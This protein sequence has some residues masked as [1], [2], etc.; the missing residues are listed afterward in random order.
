[1]RTV[2]SLVIGAGPSGLAVAYGLKGDT[3]VLEKESSVGGLCRSI[4]HGDGVF[5]IGGHSFHTPDPDVFELVQ[6]LFAGGLFH[7]RRDA[8][9]YSHDTLIP[10]PFQKYYDQLPDVDVIRSCEDG[11]RNV[12]DDP[13]KAANFE[14]YILRKFGA[15]IAEYFMLPYNRKLWARDIKKISCEWVSERVAAPKGEQ[16]KFDTSGGKRKPLQSDTNVGYPRQGGFEEIYR[17][18]VPHLTAVELN[19]TI[20]SIDPHARTAT[21]S[22]GRQYKWEILVSTLPLP[23]LVRAVAGTPAEI[24]EL[25]D[26]LEYMSLRVEFLLA[27]CR[28]ET[29]IQRIYAASPDIPAHKIALNHNS[30]DY[31]RQQPCHAIMAE[32]SLSTQK[33]VNVEEIAPRTIDFL[34]R[35]GVL[36]SPADI[37]W[38]GHVDVN[39]AYPVYTHQRPSLVNA[40]KEWMAGHDIYTVGRFGDWEYIN[41]DKCITKGLTLAAELHQIYKE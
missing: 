8:R 39:F 29:P 19:T 16:E 30:S 20:V 26:Q 33:Q 24:I 4:V 9:I 27:G 36:A 31:L 32:V 17:A 23:I 13:L 35:I 7:Q 34:C 3:L 28:L 12:K 37:I 41:S 1:M 11:L 21:T 6:N 2:K 10:Y 25:A 18:F 14:E 22:D 38:Q 5:D 40:I 15:G